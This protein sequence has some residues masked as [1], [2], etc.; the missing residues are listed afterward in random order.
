MYLLDTVVISE[1]RKRQRDP[2]VV[3]W[4]SSQRDAD[5]FLSV[6]TIGE[7][8]RGITQ[9]KIKNPHFADELAKWLDRVLILYADRV[10]PVDIETAKLWGRLSAEQGNH[11]PDLLIAATAMVHGLAV[12]TRN[13]R[14]FIPV[15]VNVLNPFSG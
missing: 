5:I 9:Q 4:L 15:G 3:E 2:A 11:G 14:H 8:E 1:M 10:L 7:I 6:V 12:V 13:E